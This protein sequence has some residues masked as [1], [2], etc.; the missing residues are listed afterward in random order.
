M[1]LSLEACQVRR[2]SAVQV[3]RFVVRA[4]VFL[5]LVGML[6]R[7]TC[8]SRPFCI[9]EENGSKGAWCFEILSCS[10]DTLLL[11]S[12]YASFLFSLLLSLLI[13]LSLIDSR[14]MLCVCPSLCMY[15][16]LIPCLLMSVVAPC[17]FVC[18]YDSQGYALLFAC[19]WLFVSRCFLFFTLLPK[20]YLSV[21][22]KH[23]LAFL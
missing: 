4:T 9:T 20:V 21:S 15:L 22:L 14:L 3:F 17:L 23:C 18:Y 8:K 6:P 1:S 11:C 12:P 7:C 16:A 2:C 13:Y 19:I 5:R 10:C